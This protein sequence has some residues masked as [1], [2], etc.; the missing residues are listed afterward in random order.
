M[1]LFSTIVYIYAILLREVVMMKLGGR[2]F[3]TGSWVHKLKKQLASARY[4]YRQTGTNVLP[5]LN[6]K[7]TQEPRQFS[8][9]NS[10]P[11]ESLAA[12]DVG[13]SLYVSSCLYINLI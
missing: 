7:L 9:Q 5:S 12:T 10:K 2:G 13:W 3:T 1:S 8:L 6:F 11:R 4:Y